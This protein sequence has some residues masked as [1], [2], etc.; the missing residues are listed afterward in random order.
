MM[1]IPVLFIVFNRLDTTKKVFSRIREA[2]PRQLFIA[3]DGPR[4]SRPGEEQK[5]QEV[6]DYVL[7]SVDWPCDVHTLFR[8]ENLGCKYAVSGAIKWFFEN[9]EAGIVLE[10]DCYPSLSFFGYCEQLLRRYE[11]DPRVGMISGHNYF[12]TIECSPYAYCFITTC[13]VWGWASWRRALCGYDADYSVL[14]D[15]KIDKVPSIIRSKKAL[16]SIMTSA[17]SAAKGEINT[18]DYQMCEYLALNGMYTIIPRKN[19]VRNIGFSQDSTH[20]SNAPSWY[21]DEHFEIEGPL[22]F[23]DG[24]AANNEVS[25]KI[26]GMFV[27]PRMGIGNWI[28]SLARSAYHAIVKLFKE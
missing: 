24:I 23:T 28:H 21:I 1:P 22:Q 19:L 26:E 4:P 9:V 27:P 14:M 17:M 7:R 12:G 13:G 3:A 15:K 5:C 16:R 25:D 8:P 18:W 11:D 20:T 2:Q 10:D 6:R